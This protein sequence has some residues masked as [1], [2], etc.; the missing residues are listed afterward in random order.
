MQDREICCYTFSHICTL[1]SG[2]Y[3]G[4]GFMKITLQENQFKK[5][6]AMCCKSEKSAADIDYIHTTVTQDIKLS[7]LLKWHENRQPHSHPH[8]NIQLFPSP[9]PLHIPCYF[10]ASFFNMLH[11]GT[12]FCQYSHCSVPECWCV[13]I[14]PLSGMSSPDLTKSALLSPDATLWW[15]WEEKASQT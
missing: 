7:L 11:H 6:Y 8:A 2:E 1:I 13:S 4:N 3:K 9:P 5:S 14:C 10:Q 12:K 15:R